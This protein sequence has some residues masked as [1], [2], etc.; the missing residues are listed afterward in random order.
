V[1]GVAAGSAA[2]VHAALAGRVD[3]LSQALDASADAQ[4]ILAPN[5]RIAYANTAFHDL[6]P[7]SD[8][9]ALAR[10][11]A[12]LGEADSIAD[13]E[14]LRRRAAAGNRA[15]TALPLRDSRGGT[16]G[17]FNIAVNPI[18]GRPGY[19]F[20][21]IQDITAH[22]EMEA[23]I[24]DERNKLVDFLEEAPIG[25]YSVD[26]V[27]RFLF[28]N[29]TLAKLLG[30]TPAEI[31][32]KDTRLHDF[33][34]LPA[35][36]ETAP[37]DPFGGR[38][39]GGQRGEV[40][41]KGRDGRA[42]PA[43]IGQSIVGD[44]PELHTRSV[45]RDLT[46]E[47]EWEAALRLSRQRFQRF[48]ANAPVGIALIDRF[49]HL[50]EANRALGELFGARP[51]DLI[52]EPLI[53]FVN[54]EDRREIA[55]KLA[56]AADGAVP[57]GPVELRLKGPRDK[58]SVVFLS[59]LDGIEGGDGG[60]M[61]HFIDATE[62]KNLEAQFA[63]SQKMQAVG[64]LAGGVAHDFNNLLTAMIGFCDL[65][66]MRFRPGDPSFADIMQVKQNANRAANLVRQLLA[67]SRRQTLQPRIIDITD[68]LV[69]LSHLL[70]RLIG[71]N[72][73]LK[74]VLGRDLGL[75]KV[76]QGQLEQVII[77]LAVNARDAMPS[78]GTL[79]IRTDNANQ[80]AALRRGPEIMPAGQYVS[81]EVADTG[82]GIPKTNL[83]RIFEPFFSTKEVGSGT[84]LG[85]STVYGI[86][87]QTGGFVFVDS[88]PGK[89]ATFQIY[90]P[91]HELAEAASAARAEPVEAPVAQDLT[92]IGTVMLVEDEDPVRIF[93]ARALRNK[94]YTVIEAKSGEAALELIRSAE[95]AP[96]LLITDVVMPRMDG[97]GLIREVRE[98]HP[99][100]K[101]IFIS[102][103]TEDSFRQ[104]LDSDSEIHFL[105]KPFSLKQLATKVK[106]V[107]SGDVA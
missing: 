16:A 64:Q 83:A 6:F 75:V 33:L 30:G 46:P 17:Q 2:W 45:V 81:I 66:L 13:F 94:G 95:R 21:N 50:E 52:G 37:F 14:R 11:A 31:V 32:G 9:P 29:H 58:T 24:R 49:G 88:A 78:G 97:P 43:W 105:P 82:V 93:G 87:K 35:P 104:R 60:L 41:L 77:N 7:Q 54:E 8:R 103:Y 68:V 47:R 18:A 70:R 59:R 40:V 4:L 67:F 44:G 42:F 62:Q 15:I 34:A 55:V 38:G 65:L 90:L 10:I 106:D 3:I 80:T 73:E 71:E 99:D 26:G 76:D 51:Q 57:P 89:G 100:M 107:I 84:G 53:E 61:L 56:A 39:D 91:R 86:V 25:F 5:G 23:M 1:I 22:H 101:V 72:I 12:A 74:V 36:L 27:G 96:D 85:L 28:V 48:F 98:I 69:E 79:T 63:Q 102:G 20:W 92:G 19:S